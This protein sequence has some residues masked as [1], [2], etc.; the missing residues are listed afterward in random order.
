MIRVLYFKP[1]DGVRND[2]TLQDLPAI[3]QESEGVV[4]VDFEDT[5]PE[6]DEPILRELFGFHPLAIDDALQETHVPKVDD[7]GN[8]LYIVLEAV[9]LSDNSRFDELAAEELDVFLGRQYMV[10]HHNR[11]IHAVESLWQYLQRDDRLLRNG[12]DAL[13]YRL[14]DDVVAGFMPIFERLDDEIDH[15]EDE[16]FN[17]PTSETLERIFSIKRTI[18]HLRRIIAP[19]RE[20]LNRLARDDYDPIDAQARVY[21]RDVYD[22][23]VRQYEITETLRDLI[24]GSLDTYLSVVNNR[25]NEI[26]RTLTVITTLFMPLTFI[27]GFFGMNFFAPVV[28]LRPWT[29][30]MAFMFSLAIM[31]ATPILMYWWMRHR[32]WF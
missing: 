8:Y 29:D 20:V 32:G 13:L 9:Y 28:N 24:G 18:V 30:S 14:T 31:A 6:T 3:L 11:P 19:Q 4:W 23:L 27:V 21:F 12:A 15:T 1:A 2:L 5:P 17:H 22:H 25:M 7:W 10:T 16:L 26:M